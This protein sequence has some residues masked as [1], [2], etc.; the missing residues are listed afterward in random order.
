MDIDGWRC[1]QDDLCVACSR[2]REEGV[3]K[4]AQVRL[5]FV[6]WN[7]RRPTREIAEARVVGA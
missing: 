3:D 7:E 2:F 5:V 6:Q 4:T 1:D